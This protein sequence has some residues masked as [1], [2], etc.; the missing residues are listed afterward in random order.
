VDSVPADG[1]SPAGSGA[2]DATAARSSRRTRDPP[3]F[4]PASLRCISY[5]WL[6]KLPASHVRVELV[7]QPQTPSGT[8]LRAARNACRCQLFLPLEIP[9]L[10]GDD[11]QVR[12]RAFSLVTFAAN[13]SDS[14]GRSV[15]PGS[16]CVPALLFVGLHRG[17]SR[18]RSRFA[19][20]ESAL[21]GP[22]GAGATGFA[23]HTAIPGPGCLLS[24]R[25]IPPP[26]AA[27]P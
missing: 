20:S 14:P 16:A 9:S 15:N 1:A 22:A 8:V 10:G 23:G 17:R 26:P 19:V 11:L 3:L 21:S 27:E 12:D 2:A 7:V 6:A 18:G 13:S 4:V 25:A 5:C 24:N